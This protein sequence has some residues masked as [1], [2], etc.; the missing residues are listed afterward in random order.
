MLILS[1]ELDDEPVASANWI[2][3]AHVRLDF[4]RL[5]RLRLTVRIKPADNP[6]DVR[7]T[8]ET[9]SVEEL[10]LTVGGEVG[11]QNA[12]GVALAA[13]GEWETGR[14]SGEENRALGSREGEDEEE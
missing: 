4:D 6:K 1:L 8:E 3:S 13:L 7:Y 9:V 12:V 14:G 2:M 10:A 11:C 5:H